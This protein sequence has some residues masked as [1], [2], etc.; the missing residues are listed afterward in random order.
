M[1]QTILPLLWCSAKT[2]YE[3]NSKFSNLWNWGDP[4]LSDTRSM[5]DILKILENNPP[6]IFGVSVYVWNEKFLDQLA[7]QVKL[8]WPNCIIVYG[9]PQ[10]NIKYTDDFFKIK[11]W[12]DFVVPS[13]AYGEII[14]KSLLDGFVNQDYS[15]IPYI[16]YTNNKREKQFNSTPIEKKS[17]NWPSNIFKS[18]EKFLLPQIKENFNVLAM[19]ETSRGCP[20]KC[21]Y[22]DWGGGTYTKISKKSFHIV[23]DELEWLAKNHVHT[24]YFTDANFGI[25]EIDVEIA[26]QVVKFSKHYGYPKHTYVENA[27]NNLDRVT[28]IQ[29]IFAEAN[30]IN[31]YKLALQTVNDDIKKNIDRIDVSFD[32]QIKSVK[33]LRENFKDLPITTET[34]LGLPGMT[35]TTAHAELDLMIENNV[36]TP[37]P[38]IWMLLPETP[39]YSKEYRDKFKIETVSSTSLDRY[40]WTLK[41]GFAPD[42]G[43]NYTLEESVSSIYN[44]EFVVKT[45]S[46]SRDDWARIFL[47]TTLASIGRSSG[48][49]QYL[50][51][52]IANVHKIKPSKIYSVIVDNFFYDSKFLDKQLKKGFTDVKNK[53]VGWAHGQNDDISMDYH[54]Q[55]PLKFDPQHFIAFLI[56]TNLQHFYKEVCLKLADHYQDDK[57]IDL[58]NYISNSI[59]DLNYNP[60]TGRNFVVDYNWQEYFCGENLVKQSCNYFLDDDE[61]L[62]HQQNQK[63]NWHLY[64]DDELSF[65][66]Q[67][68]YQSLSNL[69]TNK[70]SKTVRLLT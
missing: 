15:N 17:F 4:W 60:I 5:E 47:L 61:L 48:I 14:I 20:Y 31:R 30:L 66:K 57:I 7:Q 16:Y 49:T 53:V 52:Y 28:K 56:F 42:D 68:F 70:I 29:G 65:K 43:V 11:H 36:P 50:I 41:T 54:S 23:L 8:R 19:F 34:I 33:Y 27:K 35:I 13:D 64:K 40:G 25:M 9:G 63:I 2:Y 51:R 10:C 39:A 1:P 59:I 37:P 32:Q 22:C 21:T 18:Q 58:G 67:F 38:N 24:I 45:Y 69:Y 44:V 55:F 46:Y 62:I 6:D 12:V 3:E 26:E